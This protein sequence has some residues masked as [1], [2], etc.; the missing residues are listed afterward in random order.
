V[1]YLDPGSVNG[2]NLYAYCLNNPVMLS[3]STGCSPFWDKVWAGVTA[4]LSVGAIVVGG[5]LVATGVGAP[6]GGILIG[7]GIGGV[8]G[9]G[10]SAISQGISNGWDNINWGQVAFNSAIGMATGALMASPLGAVATGFA[11]GG[12]GFAQSVGNDLFESGGD[13]GQVNW[14]RAVVLGVVSGLI[15]GGG[16]YLTNNVTLMNKFVN[17]SSAVKS[18]GAQSLKLGLAGRGTYTAYWMNV[19]IAQTVYRTGTSAIFNLLRGGTRALIN[20]LW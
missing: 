8:I 12:L 13:W 5:I 3:D 1:S 18:L 10:G 6:L 20:L 11:V 7:A 9:W 19:M 4:V 16:K 14:G 2:L 17:S 15:A